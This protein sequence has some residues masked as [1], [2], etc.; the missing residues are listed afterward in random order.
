[1]SLWQWQSWPLWVVCT[2][3]IAAAVIDWWKFKVPNRLT[4]P[5]ILSGWCLGLMHTCGLELGGQGGIDQ[6]ATTWW[7]QFALPM[8]IETTRPI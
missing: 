4:F 5:L 1:M 3:M 6:H 2:G 8:G 7:I